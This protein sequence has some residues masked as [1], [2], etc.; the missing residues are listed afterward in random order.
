MERK[1][2]KG[3]GLFPFPRI[4]R[5]IREYLHIFNYSKKATEFTLTEIE[6]PLYWGAHEIG[7]KGK[8]REALLRR[9]SIKDLLVGFES[10]TLIGESTL[11]G[12]FRKRFAWLK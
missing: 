7:G 1:S 10:S 2:T 9:I 3:Y 5:P 6:A 11:L 12:G 4:S 8:E